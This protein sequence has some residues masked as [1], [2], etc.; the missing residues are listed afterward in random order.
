MLCLVVEVRCAKV[1]FPLVD[2]PRFDL[3]ADLATSV[4]TG[5]GDRLL[6][7]VKKLAIKDVKIKIY[8]PPERKYS[9]WIGGSILAGLATFKKVGLAAG[10]DPEHAVDRLGCLDVGQCG[11]ISRRSRYYTSQDWFLTLH[12]YCI[13]SFL[14]SSLSS[15][16][17]RVVFTMIS[18][19]YL[20]DAKLSLGNAKRRTRRER[21][22]GEHECRELGLTL[23]R[24]GS[25]HLKIE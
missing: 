18:Y 13:V 15:G 16:T 24:Y 17:L 19:A 14:Y 9:T 6:N 7:E 20:Q 11:G 3:K 2:K 22:G 8:A 10:I 5:F 25:Y 12:V 4:R 1:R 21:R 23:Q